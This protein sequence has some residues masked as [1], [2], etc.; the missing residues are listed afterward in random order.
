MLIL[1]IMVNTLGKQKKNMETQL[2]IYY[3]VIAT[4][5]LFKALLRRLRMKLL[6]YTARFILRA[7]VKFH[8]LKHKKQ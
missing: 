3:T 5:E 8:E 4:F 6:I 2:R 1:N 7:M